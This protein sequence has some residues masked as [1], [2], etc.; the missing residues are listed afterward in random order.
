MRG[1]QFR[2]K[3]DASFEDPLKNKRW[4]PFDS[5]RDA[6]SMY[7]WGNARTN[8]WRFP[9]LYSG[10][11]EQSFN[12]QNP[13]YPRWGTTGNQG[14]PYWNGLA[15]YRKRRSQR[16]PTGLSSPGFGRLDFPEKDASA[17]RAD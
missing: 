11:G 17:R 5:Q 15:S 8:Q 1:F 4:A 6:F 7:G 14:S 2:R 13:I 12:Q 10:Q 3:R 16:D 9:S